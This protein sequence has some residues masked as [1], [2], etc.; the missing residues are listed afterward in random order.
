M[1]KKDYSTY[2]INQALPV[3]NKV[4][5]SVP[6][7]ENFTDDGSKYLKTSTAHKMI[8]QFLTEKKMPRAELAEK[9]GL[10]LEEFEQFNSVYGYKKFAPT[11]SY[12]LLCLYCRTKWE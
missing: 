10:T 8:K 5:D 1:F 6:P 12:K 11:A 9:L 7:I 3:Y 4:C 2:A